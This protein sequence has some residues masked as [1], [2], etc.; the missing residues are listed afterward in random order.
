L[1]THYTTISKAIAAAGSKWLSQR[2]TTEV[3]LLNTGVG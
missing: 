3:P 2:R 1:E